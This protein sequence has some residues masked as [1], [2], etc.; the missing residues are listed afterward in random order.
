MSSNVPTDTRAKTQKELRRLRARRL[1]LR[2]GLGVGLPTLCAAIYYGVLMTPRYESESTFTIQ[3]SDG[4]MST[5]AISMLLATA[6]GSATRDVLLAIEYIESRDMLQ[7]LIDDHGFREHYTQESADVTSRLSPDADFE[8]T[9]EYYRDHISIEHDSASDVLTLRVQAFDAE[10]A[11]RF[12]EAILELAEDRVNLLSQT[13]RTDRISLA[14]SELQRAETRL[15]AARQELLRVQAVH[16][17]LNPAASAEAILE[18]RSRLEG[19]L[20]IARA[21]LSTLSATMPRNS[22]EVTAARRRVSALGT[23]IDEQNAR[24]TGSGEDISAELAQ[25]EPVMIEK[26]FAQRAYESALTSLELARV[27]ASRQHRYLVRIA[28]PSVPSQARYPRFW[29]SLLTVLA[30]AFGLLGVGTLILAS[31]REHANV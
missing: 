22:P 20:A 2:M 4:G 26:E 14:E 19:E 21:E 9:F 6:G 31:I 16:G 30:L 15:S 12:G 29:Y 3:S 13:A 28:G 24:L 25:F 7:H 11:H 23:Q 17:D 5:N 1:I 10:S 27:D 18:V 8:D